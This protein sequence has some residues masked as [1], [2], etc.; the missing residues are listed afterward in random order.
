[1]NQP[2]PE[3]F[4][5]VAQGLQFPEGPIALPDGDL[6]FVEIARGTLSRAAPGGAVTVVAR[7]GGGPNGA[8]IGPDGH[9]YVCN[10]G[11]FDWHSDADGLR[12]TG[13]ARDYTGGRI[14]RVN[15][16]TGKV[17]VLYRDVNGVGLRGPNDIVFDKQGGFWFTDAG[18]GRARELDRGGIYYARTDG[19]LIS[20]VVYPM[21]TPNGIGLSQDERTLYVAETQTGRVWSFEITS[22]GEVR[23]KPFPSP[24]G[25]T[26]VTGLGGLR[27]LDSLALDGK[28]NICVATLFDSGI[29]VVS[30]DGK[31]VRHVPVPDTFTT[32]ICFGGKGLQTAYITMSQSGRLVSVQWPDGGQVLNF[33]E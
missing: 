20:E 12:P 33:V 6:L 32:N 21:L 1:M 25:G 2:L 3:G 22:P 19:S 14:E 29:A 13:Q 11:G 16:D 27:L 4:R 9:C 7:L 24:N 30:P 26:L 17:D 5:L 31:L 8:A 23:K 18:K 10:N 28:G 15:L